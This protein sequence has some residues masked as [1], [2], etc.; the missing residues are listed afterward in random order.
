[1]SLGAYYA[2]A[3]VS[4]HHINEP[5]AWRMIRTE[6]HKKLEQDRLVESD[7]EVHHLCWGCCCVFHIVSVKM[8]VNNY[9][10]ILMDTNLTDGFFFAT[11]Y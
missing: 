9:C 10:F 8:F 5:Q 11:T 2:V 7:R 3:A 6:T 4:R 1:M